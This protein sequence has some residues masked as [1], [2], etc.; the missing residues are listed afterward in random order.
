M[1][2]MRLHLLLVL[3][4][5]RSDCLRPRL[6]PRP[7]PPRRDRLPVPRLTS[8][9]KPGAK[10]CGDDLD[11]RIASLAGPAVLSFLILPIAQA[12]DLF[13]VGRMG[14]ALALAGQAAASQ[15]YST[16]SFLTS[17]LPTITA[18][19]EALALSC[20]LALVLGAVLWRFQRPALLYLGNPN[21]LPWALGYSAGESI[22]RLP[23]VL[24]EA[25]GLIGYAAF[26]GAM[27]TVTPLKITAA[28]SAANVLLDPLLIFSARLGVAGAG[29]ATSA[30]QRVQ[31][32]DSSGVASIIVPAE[33]SSS[34][35]AEATAAAR[36]AAS[37]LLCWGVV[38]GALLG[39]VRRAAVAPSVLGA[40]LQLFNGVTFI[41]EGVM[42]GTQ[43][44]SAL[45]AGQ[46]VA[47]AALLAGLRRAHSLTAVWWCFWLFNGVPLPNAR[48]RASRP[49]G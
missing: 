28:S 21:A 39:A 44:F 47:T 9:P 36:A 18:I 35:G 43:S 7:S 20:A 3:A 27:D 17:T 45:A 15:L 11:R 13:W 38:L 16:L 8:V 41:G 49:T 26:R 31:S 25:V 42:V 48:S 12:T 10:P 30:S 40:V 14:E 24:A 19:G 37:R 34:K 29:L 23:G 6:P 32:L 22:R 1:H 5:Q 2:R 46:V 4:T 33:L